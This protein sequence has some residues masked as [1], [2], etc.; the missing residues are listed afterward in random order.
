MQATE[1]HLP[2]TEF[3]GLELR[4]H[5]PLPLPSTAVSRER[6]DV[7]VLGESLCVAHYTR[8]KTLTCVTSD[9]HPDNSRLSDF[10]YVDLVSVFLHNLDFF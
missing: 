7:S 4:Q 8:S 10:C 6:V 5:R 1:T 2:A 9:P 3:L